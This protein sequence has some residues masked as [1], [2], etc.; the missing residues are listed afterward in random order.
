MPLKLT[1][2]L[3]KKTIAEDRFLNFERA[4]TFKMYEVS[5][6]F[7]SANLLKQQKKYSLLTMISVSV[8]ICISDCVDGGFDRVMVSFNF[9]EK[10]LGVSFSHINFT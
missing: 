3:V 1:R 7:S 4:K 10:D 6:E 5:L 2:R 9:L 8:C